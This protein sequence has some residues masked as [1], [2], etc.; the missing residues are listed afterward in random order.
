MGRRTLTETQVVCRAL[1]PAN[2]Q[3]KKPDP[4]IG[5][6]FLSTVLYIRKYSF[7]QALLVPDKHHSTVGS[8]PFFSIVALNRTGR[9]H[10]LNVK[11][12][13]IYT[14]AY[15]IVNH[16]L[17]PALGEAKVVVFVTSRVGMSFHSQ[18]EIRELSHA[19]GEFVENG[20]RIHIELVGVELEVRSGQLDTAAYLINKGT[21]DSI[22]ALVDIIRDAVTV[23][24]TV[25]NWATGAVHFN[26][27]R[28]V[29]A[30]I[31][32]VHYA[33]AIAVKQRLRA[34]QTYSPG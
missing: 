18:L 27:V 23:S 30:L 29:R 21:R 15:Q 12:R 1:S 28:S 11:A 26:T 13:C 24:V 32:I 6:A 14:L 22:G 3:K 10:S 7:F 20:F 17:C 19:Q 33:V 25:L 34:G 16:S 4:M 5:P 2:S 9:T 31:N 8:T